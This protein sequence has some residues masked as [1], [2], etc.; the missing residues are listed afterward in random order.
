MES[1]QREL[2]APVPSGGSRLGAWLSRLRRSDGIYGY[3]FISPWLLGFVILTLGPLLVSFGLMFFD[4]AGLT[5]IRYVG[6]ANIHE[7]ALDT[8]FRDSLRVSVVFAF[9]NVSLALAISLGLALLVNQRFPGRSFF[10][11]VF[12]LPAAVSGVAM[13]YVWGAMLHRE[14]GMFN[15]IVRMFGLDRIGWLTTIEWA[16]RSYILMSL[17]GVGSAMVI[18]LAG[19]QSIPETLYEAAK[20]DGANSLRLFRHVTLPMLSP[21]IFFLTIVGIIG[22]LQ[23]FL[24]GYMLTQGGPVRSTLFYVLYLYTVGFTE[25][26]FGYASVLAWLL[27]LFIMALTLVQFHLARRWVYYESEAPR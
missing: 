8:R 6:L 23:M 19:L 10:R 26:R 11:S 12:Y 25:R 14:Y 18:M 4:Y 7:L 3:L 2:M 15:Q 1:Y 16:L 20:I 22:S 17:Y 13:T 5:R 24:S 21:T 9:W 27:F